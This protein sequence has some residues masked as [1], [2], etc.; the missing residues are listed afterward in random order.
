MLLEDLLATGV[1]PDRVADLA[2]AVE[3]GVPG[4]LVLAAGP[5]RS[6]NAAAVTVI[7]R[8][9]AG[10]HADLD[11]RM[12]RPD[13]GRWTLAELDEKVIRPATVRAFDRAYLLV[14]DADQM[15][16]AGHDH[17]LKTVEEPPAR[18][19]FWFC[20]T[21]PDAL[22]A[23]LRGRAG[24]VITVPAPTPAQALAILEQVAPT[25]GH[26]RAVADRVNDNITLALAVAADPDLLPA[27]DTYQAPAP[28]PAPPTEPL[29]TAEAD[30]LLAAVFR[31]AGALEAA[32]RTRRRTTKTTGKTPPRATI[33]PAVSS[34][35]PNQRPLA[36][37]LVNALLDR[38]QSDIAA[39]AHHAHTARALD[40]VDARLAALQAARAELA[41][42]ATLPLVL[43]ALFARLATGH[44]SSR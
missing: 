2:A 38:W 8:H 17:L 14:E 43:P 21:D 15:S 26:A 37:Q 16:Q 4:N 32:N 18:T 11:V 10:E 24:S 31:L 29:V 13:S 7:L 1:N 42:N 5:D 44:L 25:P 6:L 36:R 12:A 3:A 33:R 19:Q 34:L 35:T 30:R 41:T 27:L 9:L 39:E 20:L 23:T 28:Y 40:R 22:P